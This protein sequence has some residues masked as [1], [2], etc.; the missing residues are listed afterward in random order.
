MTNTRIEDVSFFRERYGR[1]RSEASLK[2][3]RWVFGGQVGANGYTT[4]AQAQRLSE[5]LELGPDSL[6]LDL[7]SGRGWPGTFLAEHSGCR[8][9]LSD[10]PLEALRQ[11]RRYA[12]AR[13]V[14]DRTTAVCVDGTAMPF[15]PGHF[16]AICHSDVFC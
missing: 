14:S 3:E 12:A 8:V 15:G 13:G 7:G 10:I 2:V 11:S 5:S 6:L 1:K 16:D 9:V 4:V